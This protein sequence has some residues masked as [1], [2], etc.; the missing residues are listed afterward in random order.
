MLNSPAKHNTREA[1]FLGIRHL[2]QSGQKAPICFL[3]IG[4]H[5]PDSR[6]QSGQKRTS[7]FLSFLSFFF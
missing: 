5:S 4:T 1:G 6:L 7:F 2:Q 3:C